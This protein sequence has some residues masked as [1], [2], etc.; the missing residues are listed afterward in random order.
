MSRPKSY[1]WFF[2]VLACMG[3]AG[4][5]APIIYNLSQ[6]L[7]PEKIAEAR[8]RWEVKGITN[9]DL[10]YLD[11]TDKDEVGDVYEIKVR[12]GEVIELR[13]NDKMKA[14]AAL[15]PEQR[16]ALTVPGMFDQMLAYLKDEEGGKR[17]NFA[18]A[19]F[20]PK[21]G[22]PARYVRRVRGTKIRLEWIVK[23]KPIEATQP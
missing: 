2:L 12:D 22:F 9:Y 21:L 17:R 19:Y 23:L 1:V 10:R 13:V 8:Q 20:D 7:T 5:L 11:R 16:H 18:T 3:A 6:L 15:T 4:V 14:V